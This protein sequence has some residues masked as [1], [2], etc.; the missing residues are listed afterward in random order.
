MK[1]SYDGALASDLARW[2]SHATVRGLLELLLSNIYSSRMIRCRPRY[3]L[4]ILPFA[5]LL[6]AQSVVAVHA[7]DHEWHDSTELCQLIKGAEQTKFLLTS[8]LSVVPAGTPMPPTL[9]LATS[10][11]APRRHHRTARAPPASLLIS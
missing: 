3:V 7:V 4:R 9:V 1:R 11:I 6:W 2:A 5:L 8:A 10:I